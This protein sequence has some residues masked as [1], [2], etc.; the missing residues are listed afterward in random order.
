[1]LPRLPLAILSLLAC[2]QGPVPDRPTSRPDSR[3]SAPAVAELTVR[4]KECAAIPTRRLSTAFAFQI[5]A[6]AHDITGILAGS[7]EDLAFRTFQGADRQDGKDA[8][9]RL[10]EF[11]GARPRPAPAGQEH[12]LEQAYDLADLGELHLLIVRPASPAE[13]LWILT[14]AK[15]RRITFAPHR[16]H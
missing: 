6:V 16:N 1:M 15:G 4:A 2:P 12:R 7:R 5:V 8:A 13:A 14:D 9:T 3:G 10:L 11:L